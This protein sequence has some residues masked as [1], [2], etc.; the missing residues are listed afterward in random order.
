LFRRWIERKFRSQ[1]SEANGNGDRGQSLN[2][3]LKN[4]LANRGQIV[5]KQQV[6][7]ANSCKL[8]LA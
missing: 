2:L 3:N 6:N 5:G 4:P 8:W 7:I 1:K